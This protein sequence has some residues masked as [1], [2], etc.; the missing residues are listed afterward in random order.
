M[1]I[2][3]KYRT[4][5]N[6]L[7]IE[8]GCNAFIIKKNN[9]YKNTFLITSGKKLTEVDE[10]YGWGGREDGRREYPRATMASMKHCLQLCD[11]KV[12]QLLLVH[13]VVY[14]AVDLQRR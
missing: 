8:L 12:L 2:L 4:I 14:T 7:I 9:L 6:Y 3:K 10:I 1:L 11:F 5:K 13:Y